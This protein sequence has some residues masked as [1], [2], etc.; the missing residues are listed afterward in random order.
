MVVKKLLICVG[1]CLLSL[2]AIAEEYWQV[3]GVKSWDT[4]N[5]RSEP[6]AKS[7]VIGEIPFDGKGIIA[8]GEEQNIGKTVWME[9]NWANKQGWVSKAYLQVM[10]EA[11]DTGSELAAG[12]VD[13]PGTFKSDSGGDVQAQPFT[14]DAAE[15]GKPAKPIAA[16]DTVSDGM[17]DL[18]A[19]S[20]LAR[21]A[22]ADPDSA[23]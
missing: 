2:S 20:V 3:S 1:L 12:I 4:L 13:M 14:A 23:E 7:K 9:I 19:L 11:A 21:P 16:G 18:E 17:T 22:I 10:P 8:T 15:S 6:G 5:I